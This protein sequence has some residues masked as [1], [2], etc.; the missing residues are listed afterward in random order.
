MTYYLYWREFSYEGKCARIISF[1]KETQ[2]RFFFFEGKVLS[3]PVDPMGKSMR[4]RL[5]GILMQLLQRVRKLL[6]KIIIVHVNDKEQLQ[7]I[8]W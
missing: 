6:S 3:E 4:R 1:M 7:R 2:A 5:Q 8:K